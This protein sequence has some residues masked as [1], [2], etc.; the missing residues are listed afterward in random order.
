MKNRKKYKTLVGLTMIETI[1]TIVITTI[2]MGGF[3]YLFSRLWKVYGFTMETGLATRKATNAL[4]KAKEEIIKAR[5]SEN[6]SYPIVSANENEFSFYSDYDNDGVV[7]KIRYFLDA[8]QL[9]V[10]IIE[11]DISQK[12]ISYKDE[13]ETV[14]TVARYVVNDLVLDTGVTCT[15]YQLASKVDGSVGNKFVSV[16]M[17]RNVKHA[18]QYYF[19]LNGNEFSTQVTDDGWVLVAAGNRST[20][21]SNYTQVSDLYYDSDSILNSGILAN[22]TNIEQIRIQAT[23]ES[24]LENNLPH[25]VVTSD[26]HMINDIIAFRTFGHEA[27]DDAVWECYDSSDSNCSEQINRMKINSATESGCN[28]DDLNKHLYFAC[29]NANGFSWSLNDGPTG[30]HSEQIKRGNKGNDIN[31]FVRGAD[32]NNIVYM[33]AIKQSCGGKEFKGD[34][35]LCYSEQDLIDAGAVCTDIDGTETNKRP[36]F[37]YYGDFESLS[38]FN[39]NTIL[40]SKL[41]SPVDK[42]KIKLIRILLNINVDPKQE[43]ENTQVETFINIRNLDSKDSVSSP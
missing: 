18:G 15:Q 9:K 24:W 6:G 35:G 40:A 34:D 36:L 39:H 21:E 11:P 12:P 7:E 16:G 30:I 14:K 20:N 25:D 31:L 10:G 8:Q 28:S 1:M 43:K 3:T 19:N 33:T 5:N 4:D 29:G 23:N 17:A 22:F 27:S 42:T 26:S 13:T 32:E 38:D 37:T 2:V 41:S